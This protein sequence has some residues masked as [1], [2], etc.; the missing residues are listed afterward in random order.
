MAAVRRLSSGRWINLVTSIISHFSG[1]TM[2][3]Q[4]AEGLA[5]RQDPA[6]FDQV[7]Q[8]TGA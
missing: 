6:E 8:D 1:I 5:G 4:T 7:E 2:S 3:V